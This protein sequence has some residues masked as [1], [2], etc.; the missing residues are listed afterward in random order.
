MTATASIDRQSQATQIAESLGCKVEVRRQVGDCWDVRIYG[1]SVY[2][3]R[4]DV[5]KAN[6]GLHVLQMLAESIKGLAYKQA[7]SLTFT[8]AVELL[9]S[10]A[11]T[12]TT[13]DA[14][15]VYQDSADKT[16]V[17]LCSQHRSRFFVNNLAAFGCGEYG[18]QCAHCS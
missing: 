11:T 14:L 15:R 8:K 6:I 17:I 2:N 12:G 5:S 3:R 13:S 18:G 10:Q 7:A 1:T 16:G 4:R 9:D